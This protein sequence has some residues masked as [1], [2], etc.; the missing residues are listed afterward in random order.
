MSDPLD[1]PVVLAFADYFLPGYRAGGPV[2]SLAGLAARLG[3]EFRFHVVTRDRDL[4]D[5]APY[6][7]LPAGGEG[8][9]GGARVTYLA[10]GMLSPGALPRIAR[11]AGA[12]VLYLNSLFSPRFSLAPLVLRAAGR[13]PGLPLVLAPRGEL[14]PGAL[15]LNAP[16]KR[17]FLAA[18]RAARLH[19][20]VLWQASSD[21][22]A[23]QV[24]RWFP[25]AEVWVAPNLAPPGAVPL[26]REPKLPG[27]L[28]AA[29]VARVSPMKNLLGA[30]RIL[31]GTGHPTSLDVY[32]PVEDA[33]YWER[34]RAAIR[35][36]PPHVTV[37][38]HG[39]VPPS[40]VP[41]VLSRAH[42]L[43]LPTLGENYG[44]AVREA[45]AAGCLPL[46]SDRTP[47][48]GLEARGVGWDLPLEDAAAWHA[49]LRRVAAM[50]ADTFGAWSARAAAEGARAAEDPAAEAQ[51]RALFR[52]AVARA[53]RG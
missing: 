40:D 36:L 22:E 20:G 34:C 19:R 39:P 23:E 5:G 11:G 51:S 24:R 12:R 26:P 43:L 33:A 28:R 2:A 41:A 17:A 45:M 13:L 37:V 31:A 4:G 25:G 46:V 14:A 53:V 15:A 9:A 44:H 1:R 27:E 21:G 16:R 49:V 29:F 52:A 50:D 30:L 32:G 8:A 7:E 6:A 42:V 18:A 35:R 48:R 3:D 47:W 10:P 38:A